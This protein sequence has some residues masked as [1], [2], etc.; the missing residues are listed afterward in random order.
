MSILQFSIGGVNVL[1]AENPCAD[2]VVPHIYHH[3]YGF[4][5][6]KQ[7]RFTVGAYKHYKNVEFPVGIKHNPNF[8]FNWH[9]TSWNEYLNVQFSFH[10]ILRG[11]YNHSGYKKTSDYEAARLYNTDLINKFIRRE[12]GFGIIKNSI[13]LTEHFDVRRMMLERVDIGLN[14]GCGNRPDCE[15]LLDHYAAK[16][17]KRKGKRLFR[18]ENGIYLFNKAACKGVPEGVVDL[19]DVAKFERQATRVL[20]IYIK[21]DTTVRFETRSIGLQAVNRAVE[22]AS[23]YGEIKNNFHDITNLHAT[24]MLFWQDVLPLF[25]K[26]Q[27]NEIIDRYLLDTL[28]H[29]KDSTFV[30]F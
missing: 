6:A 16:L 27:K 15:K 22:R 11:G 25:N 18:V 3:L 9:R 30:N 12:T 7:L 8:A 28:P 1:L 14:V 5:Q 29:F 19:K 24:N 20:H 2:T 4:K 23:V 17:L 21:N 26:T 13:G 10:K